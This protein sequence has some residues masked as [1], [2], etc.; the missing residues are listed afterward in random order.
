[1][2]RESRGENDL[3]RKYE[4]YLSDTHMYTVIYMHVRARYIRIH[5]YTRIYAK[6]LHGSIHVVKCRLADDQS[7]LYS[8]LS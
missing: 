6:M 5:T 4:Y 3:N 7:L 1:M 2:Y 8:K